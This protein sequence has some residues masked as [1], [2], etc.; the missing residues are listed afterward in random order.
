[1]IITRHGEASFRVQVGEVAIVVDP[2]DHRLKAD[3]VLKTKT[4]LPLPSTFESALV[5]VG[6]GE[7]DSKGVHILGFPANTKGETKNL[8]TVYKVL[9]EDLALVFLGTPSAVPDVTISE[10]VGTV[11][12]LF[13]GLGTHQLTKQLNPKIIVAVGF[14]N[15]ATARKEFNHDVADEEKVVVKKNSLPAK[16][17][18]V[19]LKF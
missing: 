11:D 12:I 9:F 2:E 15:S 18:V 10:K 16:L 17:S 6:P 5:I 3:V 7:Y 13:A 14:K 1:M 8:E 19:Q 4:A